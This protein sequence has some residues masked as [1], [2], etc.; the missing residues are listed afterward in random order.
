M[1]DGFLRVAAATPDVSVADIAHNVTNIIARIK[2]ANSR[3]AKVVVFPELCM[4]GYT[5]NDLF[6]QEL[7]LDKICDGLK[8]ILAASLSFC[9][10][11]SIMWQP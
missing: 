3:D 11:L 1:K 10:T 4:T 2:E 8:E 9:T 6:L 7:L 5:C